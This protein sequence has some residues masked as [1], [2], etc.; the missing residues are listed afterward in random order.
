MQSLK[1]SYELLTGFLEHLN[2]NSRLEK[3]ITDKLSDLVSDPE[4]WSELLWPENCRGELFD[5]FNCYLFDTVVGGSDWAKLTKFA[6][7]F[8]EWEQDDDL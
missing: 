5:E 3:V 2:K 6:V 1:C 4:K 8:Y 7:D